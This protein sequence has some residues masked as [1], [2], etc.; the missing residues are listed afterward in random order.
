MNPESRRACL[1]GY[2]RRIKA[3]DGANT[4]A[5]AVDSNWLA[6]QQILQFEKEYDEA[7]GPIVSTV[8]KVSIPD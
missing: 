1:Q 8:K 2:S 7:K 3:D 4:V 5:G 6:T